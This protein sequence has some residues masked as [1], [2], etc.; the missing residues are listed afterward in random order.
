MARKKMNLP[1]PLSFQSINKAICDSTGEYLRL[2]ARRVLME[3]LRLIVP[4]YQKS[5]G[6]NV[7]GIIEDDENPL[8]VEVE[9]F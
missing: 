9:S 4:D 6:K 2:V 5:T 7:Q 1:M 3:D 8:S